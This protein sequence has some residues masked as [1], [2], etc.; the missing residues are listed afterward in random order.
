MSQTFVMSLSLLFAAVGRLVA[1][2]RAAVG[3]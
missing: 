3:V 2:H 1:V